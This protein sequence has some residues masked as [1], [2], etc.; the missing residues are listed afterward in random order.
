MHTINPRPSYM[1]LDAWREE[2]SDR[3]LTLTWLLRD[4]VIE[5]EAEKPAEERLKGR[6]E[7]LETI[8][9]YALLRGEDRGALQERLWSYHERRH[10]ELAT[11]YQRC[12]VQ[13]ETPELAPA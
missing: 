13:I 1:P 8:D 3:E 2:V 10:P 9:N 5:R 6:V 7:R 11:L 4:E 12:P